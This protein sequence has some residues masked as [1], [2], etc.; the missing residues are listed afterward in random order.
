MHIKTL[1]TKHTPNNIIPFI[2]LSQERKLKT[3]ELF[4][5]VDVLIVRTHNL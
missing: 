5:T 1:I 4:S 2:L 3:L